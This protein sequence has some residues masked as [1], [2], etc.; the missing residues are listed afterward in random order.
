[1]DDIEPNDELADLLKA[2]SEGRLSPGQHDRLET[3]LRADPEARTH[4]LRYVHTDTLLTWHYAPVPGLPSDPDAA[5]EASRN[6]EMLSD[7]ERETRTS[8]ARGL[9]PNVGETTVRPAGDGRSNNAVPPLRRSRVGNLFVLGLFLLAPPGVI[10]S[11]VYLFA[12]YGV[13]LPGWVS[14]ANTSMLR[15]IGL[16]VPAVIVAW[17]GARRLGWVSY[18][19]LSGLGSFATTCLALTTGQIAVSDHAENEMFRREQMIQANVWVSYDSV[20][21]WPADLEKA[22]GHKA[23][24]PTEKQIRE[25]LTILRKAGFTGLYLHECRTGMTEVPRIAREVGFRAVVQGIRIASPTDFDDVGTQTQVRNALSVSKNVDAYFL[26]ELSAREVDLIALKR[27]LAVIRWKTGKPVTTCFVHDDYLGER[28][29]RLRELEDFSVRALMR[30]WT[31]AT[32]DPDKAVLAVKEALNTFREDDKPSLLTT[33]FYPSGGGEGF[34]PDNQRRF[35][36]GVRNLR[37]PRGVNVVYFNSFDRPWARKLSEVRT[38]TPA[39]EGYTGLFAVEFADNGSDARFIAKP[40]AIPF[41]PA[42]APSERGP[43]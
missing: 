21:Y 16:L 15:T 38:D 19:V 42:E 31:G 14:S 40:A 35:M 11:S 9:R 3:I 17:L 30:P 27:Q 41:Q 13:A 18:P 33:V 8:S 5:D 12:D 24:E 34:T 37:I 26:G 36:V 25:E 32:A 23:Q 2:V 29:K 39:F 22:T 20:H 43:Q 28:G 6:I 1:M 7:C 4:Y 10:A